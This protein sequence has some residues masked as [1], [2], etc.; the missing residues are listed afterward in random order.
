MIVD[1]QKLT[2][3]IPDIIR[4]AELEIQGEGSGAQRREF[5]MNTINAVID[6]PFLSETTEGRL[7]GSL[8]DLV[9]A[10]FN[11]TFGKNWGKLIQNNGG[12]Q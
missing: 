5:V 9:V 1:W 2:E 10:S 4:Q 7:L 11:R 8:I 6:V 3:L 12:V